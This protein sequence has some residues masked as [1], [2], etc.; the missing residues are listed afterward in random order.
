[1]FIKKFFSISAV[2]LAISAGLG[3]SACGGG[4]DSG[5]STFTDTSGSAA[6]TTLKLTDTVVGTG[7]SADVGKTATVHYTGW[8]Y[9]VKVADTR[10]V[11]FDSSVGKTPYEFKV[12]AGTVIKGWDDG[13][14]GM[15]VG[16]KRT[17]T[18]PSSLGYGPTGAGN[19]AI[20]ANAALV[21]DV[22]LLSVK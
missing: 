14:A 13:V 7:V 2:V 5:T 17:L 10:G 3:L 21:F 11:K 9:D 18:I 4:G 12:G 22:E 19:G 6:V 15:K 8:L 20:P 1:M 16:G